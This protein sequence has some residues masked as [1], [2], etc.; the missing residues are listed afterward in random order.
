MECDSPQGIRESHS[1]LGDKRQN[2]PVPFTP[3]HVAALLP[4]LRTPLPATGLVI[5]S[6]V[7]D[8]P[9]FA[10][11]G[12]SRGLTHSV[13]GVFTADLPMGLMV[14]VLWMLVFRAPVSD[15]APKWL[16]ARLPEMMP[17]LAAQRLRF[18][19]YSISAILIGIVTHLAWDSFTHPDGW[20]V[21]AFPLFQ[22]GLGPFTVY[23]WLQYGSSI[24]GL[25]IVAIWLASWLRRT[26]PRPELGSIRLTPVRRITSWF[27]VSVPGLAVALAV[28][29]GGIVGGVAPLDRVLVYRT[30]TLS[31]S[32]AGFIAIL[33]VVLWYFLPRRPSAVPGEE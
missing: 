2:R 3:S 16:R 1:C 14:L 28:W 10:P 20:L 22:F 23:R 18:A 17:L 7:P 4:I 29:V 15:F 6:M 21:L 8:L 30:A 13:V 9:Y 12:V 25:T 11:I 32:C 19:L 24:A 33:I 31:I 5:G 27:L 26:S